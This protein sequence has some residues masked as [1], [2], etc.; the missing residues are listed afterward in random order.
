M[1]TADV[2]DS[3]LTTE[4]SLDDLSKVLLGISPEALNQALAWDEDSSLDDL[5]DLFAHFS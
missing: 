4:R 3:V 5:M 1:N 2:K